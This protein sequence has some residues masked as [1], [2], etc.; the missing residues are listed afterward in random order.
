MKS[1]KEEAEAETLAIEEALDEQKK[2]QE[3]QKAEK[4]SSMKPKNIRP[5]TEDSSDEE[6]EDA[7][8]KTDDKSEEEE[9]QE[10][11]EPERIFNNQTKAMSKA[12]EALMLSENKK[13]IEDEIKQRKEDEAKFMYEEQIRK[14]KEDKEREEKEKLVKEVKMMKQKMIEEEQEQRRKK[15]EEER[16]KMIQDHQKKNLKSIIKQ[17]L[18]IRSMMKMTSQE[19]TGKKMKKMMLVMK[20]MKGEVAMIDLDPDQVRDQGLLKEDHTVE[21]TARMMGQGE[22][23]VAKLDHEEKLQME[24]ML[25]MEKWRILIVMLKMKL[26]GKRINYNFWKR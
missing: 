11:E 1:G 12:R 23:K 26:K 21:M 15:I 18:K 2:K 22:R 17:S 9:E 10:E 25:R 19:F 6:N 24:V 3:S 8:D 7:N 16:E 14:E 20:I 5:R 13:A 4:A